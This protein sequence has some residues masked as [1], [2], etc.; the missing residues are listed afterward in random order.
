M[1]PFKKV[2]N[3]DST[4]NVLSYAYFQVCQVPLDQF[5]IIVTFG[6]YLVNILLKEHQPQQCWQHFFWIFATPQT[7]LSFSGLQVPRLHE[8][9]FPMCGAGSHMAVLFLQQ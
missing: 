9:P 6:Y 4:A 5:D 2:K 8:C 7:R 1:S 3:F